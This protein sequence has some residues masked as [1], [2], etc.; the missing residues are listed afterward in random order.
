MTQ[1][2]IVGEH[3]HQQRHRCVRPPDQAGA[4]ES[5]AQGAERDQHQV[6]PR[7]DVGPLVGQD[8]RQLRRIVVG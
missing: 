8:R 4:G 5:L 1:R 3:L 6:V 7:P 2:T